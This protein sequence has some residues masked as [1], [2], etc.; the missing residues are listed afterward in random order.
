MSIVILYNTSE[1]LWTKAKSTGWPND[2]NDDNTLLIRK[3]SHTNQ[4]KSH[5]LTM[6]ELWYKVKEKPPSTAISIQIIS[7]QIL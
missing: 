3:I 6:A 5:I 2:E 4:T 1:V 7:E